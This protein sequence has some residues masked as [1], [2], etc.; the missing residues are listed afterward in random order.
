M[1]LPL[2]GSARLEEAPWPLKL[3]RVIVTVSLRCGRCE[4]MSQVD[5]LAA[6]DWLDH[7]ALE[8]Q[9]EL[10]RGV[11]CPACGR[12]VE[13]PVPLVQHRD[14]DAVELLVALPA[15]TPAEQDTAWIRRI[16]LQLRDHVTSTLVVTVRSVWWDAISAVALGPVLAKLTEP[17][18]LPETA[19]ETQAWLASTRA[20]LDLPDV[21]AALGR[22]VSA[23]SVDQARSV[24]EGEPSLADS[25]WQP[26]LEVAGKRLVS[27]QETDEQREVVAQRLSRLRQMT[28]NME[29]DIAAHPLDQAAQQAVDAAVT[30]AP[31][32]PDRVA[33]IAEAVDVLRP[34]GPSRMLGA[35]LTSLVASMMAA[36]ERSMYQW[37]D[38]RVLAEEAISVCRQVFG[39]EHEATI[40][41]VLNLLLLRQEQPAATTEEIAAV[42]DQYELL[43]RS[44][45]IRR[46]RLLVDV[47]NNLASAL[48]L[49]GD[50]SR[51]ERLEL[52]LSLFESVGHIAGLTRPNDTRSHILALGNQ[53]AVL[54][55]RLA[56]ARLH[57][58]ER[59]WSLLAHAQ[60][61]AQD[62]H[63]LNAAERVQLLATKLN[64]AYSLYQIGAADRDATVVETLREV[65][66]AVSI[67]DENNAIAI[68]VL[69]NAGSILVDVY[70]STVRA[71]WPDTAL[72]DEAESV[73]TSAVNR[74]LRL[75]P[76]GQRTRLTALLNLAS[77]YGAPVGANVKDAGKAAE[78]Y[79]QVAKE[80]ETRSLDHVAT[81]MANLGTLSVG[82]GNWEQ[83]A[84]SYTEARRA[85][86]QL[87]SQ[88]QSRHT[89][90]GEVIASGD[91]A[92]REALAYV[93]LGELDEAVNA[94]EESR[95]RLL[96]HRFDMQ[97]RAPLS[98]PGRV[99]VHLA[100]CSLGTIA[101]VQG[102]GGE[103]SAAFG[104]QS[105]SAI[106]ALVTPLLQGRSRIQRLLAFDQVAFGLRDLFDAVT[107]MLPDDTSEICVVACGPLA[108]VP[109]HGLAGR[110]GSTWLDSYQ[111]RYWPSAN[112][113]AYIGEPHVSQIRQ[114]LAVTALG[115]DLP[116]AVTE[117]EA[118]AA[119]RPEL[120]RPPEDWSVA[121]WLRGHLPE[122]DLAH[123]ACHAR[124]DPVDP[125]GSVFEI[126]QD[127][128]VTLDE[129]LD[130]PELKRL[131]L[132]FASA[133]QAG[134]PAA[135]APD[136]LLGIAYGLVH[137]GARAA[138]TSLWE[139]NDLPAALLVARFY[140]ELTADAHPASALRAAQLWLAHTSNAE[141]ARLCQSGEPQAAWLPA[142]LTEKLR[143]NVLAADPDD[144]PF[145]HGSDWATFTYLGA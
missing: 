11:P 25:R 37:S 100:S 83:A 101:V 136:E 102:H 76:P 75:F 95:A 128:I 28:V 35:A 81:A 99:I 13:L 3:P 26:T 137:A 4:V 58:L 63:A 130:G 72:L 104:P 97:A 107:S 122:V 98:R 129:L 117:A 73:L 106:R 9:R 57:N 14:F 18:P 55:Q 46:A 54:R 80:A 78:L 20:S 142:A 116:L 127:E 140:R 15:T 34:G 86:L 125:T 56:G 90:L 29:P 69:I 51:G 135:D 88:T 38:L 48:D 115:D 65:I 94:L 19:E 44:P 41:N 64:L 10:A 52:T 89:R 59:G 134:A 121:S 40:S 27:I 60:F 21:V 113:A 17:P 62:A 6:A 132:V 114:V 1:D 111:V 36:P 91:L 112:I 66:A 126:S 39:D 42:C 124:A 108:G 103:K 23:V 7:E 68:T 92:A 118:L 139:V 50:L 31:G 96:R 5:L 53:A 133:C 144:R 93:R 8:I 74:C 109:F 120:A 84:T 141:L 77:V 143:S 2:D 49:R 70:V 33:I 24:F 138:I 82:Q 131:Q 61:L 22:F 79:R 85:R 16:V 71:N 45:A 87:V 47:L 110:D 12:R 32:D 123:F 30:Q 145:R 67:L 105:S 119:W 43:L